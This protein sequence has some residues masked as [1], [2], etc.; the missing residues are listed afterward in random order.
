VLSSH[1]SSET[2]N[3]E[4][5]PGREEE[6]YAPSAAITPHNAYQEILF[7]RFSSAET[8]VFHNSVGSRKLK[9]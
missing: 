3:T 6:Y 8:V 2:R 7:P 1:R 9:A 4:Q 5:R